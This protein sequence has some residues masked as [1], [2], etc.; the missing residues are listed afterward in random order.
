M[1]RRSVRHDPISTSERDR[2]AVVVRMLLDLGD[3]VPAVQASPAKTESTRSTG[4]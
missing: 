3:A 1:K 4:K 2:G